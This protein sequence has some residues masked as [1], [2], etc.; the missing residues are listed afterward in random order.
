MIKK[1]YSDN[2]KYPDP[3]NIIEWIIL[4]IRNLFDKEYQESKR[5][6]ERLHS[7]LPKMSK[8]EKSKQFLAMRKQALITKREGT[9]SMKQK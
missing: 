3:R 2:T 5:R 4:K 9:S 6:Y 1:Y 7:P 8:S